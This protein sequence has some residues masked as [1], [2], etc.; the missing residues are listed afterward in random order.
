MRKAVVLGGYGLIGAACCRALAEAGFTVTAVGRSRAAAAASGL[1]V[2][3]LFRDLSREGWQDELSGVDVV[4]NAAGALQDGPRDDLNAIHDR[5]VERLLAA[6]AGSGT[7]LIQISAAGVSPGAATEF[8]RSKARGDAR[9]MASG[10]DAVILRPVLVLAPAAY[11]GTALLRAVAAF[12]LVHPRVFPEAPVQCLWIGDL[13]QAV[14]AA[15]EGR[16]APGVYDL[17]EPAPSPF[18]NTTERLRAWLGLPRWRLGVTLPD[19]A[20]R[21]VGR[22]ADAL[23]RLGWRS[24]LRS[25]AL[26]SLRA[27]VTGD[28]SAWIAAGG[29]PCR[30]LGE[31]LA[32]MPATTQERWFARMFLLLPLAIG[33]LALFWAASGL[34]AL[35]QPG[36]SAAV[37]TARGMAEAPALAIALTGALVDLALGL[38]ILWRRWARAAAL[39][40]VAVA[41]AYL[42]GSLLWT[43]DLWLDPMGPMLKVLPS[44]PLA[45]I[46]AA[47][48]EPR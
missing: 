41:S 12:P 18:A 14:V 15:A 1:A 25:N 3:W 8:I 28:P 39:G 33:V 24:P 22:W 16:V 9:V 7:R 36:R 46:T 21:L 48:M 26:V 17:A 42:A 44:L 29:T 2:R 34:I 11:G 23:G 27:G 38:A 10:L 6:L 45:L 35:V 20:V 4:V 19:V 40:M 47:L 31:M 13:V 43:P 32:L 30:S 5:A 37:L